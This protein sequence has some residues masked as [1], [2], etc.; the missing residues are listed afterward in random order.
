[1]E[2]D[3][4]A[5]PPPI[6]EIR[7]KFLVLGIFGVAIVLASFA[8]WW[9]LRQNHQIMSLWGM[10]NVRLIR[11]A[12]QV[13][14]WDLAPADASSEDDA[15]VVERLIVEGTSYQILRRRHI[16]QARGLI[17]ARYALTEDASFDWTE[18]QQPDGSDQAS[19]RW[20]VRFEE[21]SQAATLLIAPTSHRVRLL[22]T[23]RQ[24]A[25]I[26]RIIAGWEKLAER[27]K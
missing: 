11:Q 25:A 2:P 17:H 5:A 24:A 7:G 3:S 26:P 18:R 15:N 12:K 16:S 10:A 19:W 27:E 6:H 23:K 14:L 4:P 13:E 20:A 21:G 1:M 9:N 8:W 22:E